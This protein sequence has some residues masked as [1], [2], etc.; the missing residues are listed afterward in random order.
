MAE[1]HTIAMLMISTIIINKNRT[2][3]EPTQQPLPASEDQNDFA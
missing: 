1:W 2:E 3:D